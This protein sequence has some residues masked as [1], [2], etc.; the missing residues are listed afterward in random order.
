M[1]VHPKLRGMRIVRSD[2]EMPA[3]PRKQPSSAIYLLAQD[4]LP[5]TDRAYVGLRLAYTLQLAF[6]VDA[7]NAVLFIHELTSCQSWLKL[8]S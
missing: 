8:S 4:D 7:L 3:I 5:A 1:F 2:L 6:N